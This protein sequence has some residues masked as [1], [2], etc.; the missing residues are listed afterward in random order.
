MLRINEAREVW[1][2]VVVQVPTDEGFVEEEVRVRFQLATTTEMAERNV[3]LLPRKVKGWDG[4]GD[5]D[6]N[7]LPYSDENLKRLIENPHVLR[8]FTFALAECSAGAPRKN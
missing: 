2:P 8:A 4:I 5:A 3:D 1:W 7:A 6:G